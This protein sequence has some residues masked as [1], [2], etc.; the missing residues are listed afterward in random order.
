MS[1]NN[2]L[3]NIYGYI[4][5]EC[6]LYESWVWKGQ[7][8]CPLKL[9]HKWRTGCINSTSLHLALPFSSNTSQLIWQ[10]IAAQPEKVWV[11]FFL[12]LFQRTDN[13]TKVHLTYTSLRVWSNVTAS[14]YL[15]NLNRFFLSGIVTLWNYVIVCTYILRFPFGIIQIV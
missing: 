14:I 13:S 2:I 7:W 4:W 1:A 12:L 3:N 15:H 10:P 11:W 8:F 5:F 6:L 9:K